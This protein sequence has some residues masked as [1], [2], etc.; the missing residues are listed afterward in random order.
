M[1]SACGGRW[2]EGPE[3]GEV[4]RLNPDRGEG[5]IEPPRRHGAKRSVGLRAERAEST[6]PEVGG[7]CAGAAQGL[8]VGRA[9]TCARWL[10][11]PAWRSEQAVPAEDHEL[12]EGVAIDIVGDRV[13]PRLSHHQILVAVA[14]IV[15]AR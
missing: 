4:E 10:G 3:G 6:G 8:D 5:A 13:P 7:R 14:I 11:G 9:W 2:P 15:Q 12:S 1:M